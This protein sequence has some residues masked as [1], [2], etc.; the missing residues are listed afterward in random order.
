MRDEEL[1]ELYEEAFGEKP[2]I[3]HVSREGEVDVEGKPVD[4]VE[5]QC[6]MDE[7]DIRVFFIVNNRDENGV[8]VRDLETA[9]EFLGIFAAAI[10][11]ERG[12]EN[13]L[14]YVNGLKAEKV[15]ALAKALHETAMFERRGDL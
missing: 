15:L 3:C 4:G 11:A 5:V 1:E 13:S 7:D 2:Y 14:R 12:F 6:W 10:F 9:D 8:W